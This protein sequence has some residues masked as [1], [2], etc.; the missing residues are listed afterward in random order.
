M[1]K[2]RR[3]AASHDPVVRTSAQRAGD[4]AEA[5]AAEYLRGLGWTIL[6]RNVHVGRAEI[7]LLA[8]DHVISGRSGRSEL[9]VVE[10]RW[11]V[12]RDFGLAEEQVPRAKLIRLRAAGLTL[13]SAGCLPSGVPVPAGPLRLDLIVLEPG[14]PIR[15]HRHVG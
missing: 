6:G 1:D 8:I 7:D 11:R 13:R 14:R 5:A 2:R 10:V 9:V 3:T 15:H 4:A 12:R